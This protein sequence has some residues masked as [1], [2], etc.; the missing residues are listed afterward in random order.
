MKKYSMKLSKL[1]PVKG[2]VEAQKHEL[3]SSIMELG[4]FLR[5]NNKA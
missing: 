5:H 4:K 3:N 1:A 2:P